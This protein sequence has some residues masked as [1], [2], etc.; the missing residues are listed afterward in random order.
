MSS[1]A[2]QTRQL[3][4]WLQERPRTYN[5]AL[6][7]WHTHC[8]RLTVW[9]DAVIAGLVRIE[10]TRKGSQVRVTALGRATMNGR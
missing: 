4:T 9:E 6:E 10:R 7:A 5:E 2:A 8:P 1:T 3:L